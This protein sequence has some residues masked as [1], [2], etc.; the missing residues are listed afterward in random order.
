M[1]KGRA[2]FVLAEASLAE[3]NKQLKIN[4]LV[5]AVVIAILAMNIIQ[6]MQVKSFFYAALTA[7]MIFL[8]FFITKARH[9]LK[10]RKQELSQ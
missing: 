3:V 9:I 7:L 6:F 8:L 10:L 1:K 5:T 2:K 4:W